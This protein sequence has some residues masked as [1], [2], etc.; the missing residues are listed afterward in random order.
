[1]ARINSKIRTWWG[2]SEI[3]FSTMAVMETSFF[4]VF[5][6]DAAQLP[7]PLVGAIT[8][9][10]GIA[11]AIS[12]VI[13]GAVIDRARLKGGKY[14]PWLVFC[15]PLVVLFFIFEFTRIGGD[16][17]A[18][19]ICA[20]G[21]IIGHFIWNIGW[22]ANRSLIGVLTD[23]PAERGFLSGRI[24]AGSCGGKL[25]GSYAVPALTTLFIGLFAALGPVF[26]YTITAAIVSVLY[27]LTYLIHYAITK[28]YD[29]PDTSGGEKAS[30]GATLLDIIKTIFT[31]PQLLVVVLADSFR[32]VGFYGFAAVAAYYARIVI[33]DASAVAIILIIFNGGAFV[34]SLLSGTVVRKLGT[35][36]VTIAG[37]G[38]M[39][40]LFLFLYFVPLPL[41]AFYV[42]LA[43]AEVVF[44]VSYGLTSSLYSMCGTLSE[45]QKGVDVK[46][47]AMAG[48]SLAIKVS[49]AVRGVII[50][51]FL[52]SIG[53]SADAA[54][55]ASMQAGI[56]Q[57][58][59]LVPAV[60]SLVS[61]LLF[62]L[63]RIKDD[64]I[65]KMEAEIAARKNA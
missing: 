17:M 60:F 11:D 41:V 20:A 49:I 15:P 24:A 39:A 31:N 21:Y 40:I 44:G 59:L 13:A 28:G 55:T 51:S 58:F 23:D 48:S 14:R 8:G 7:L 26:G 61:A 50:A 4:L 5:L 46:G 56:S 36:L 38:I 43:V 45:Y 30:R 22:T 63:Y 16:V 53:Y 47:M 64:D 54:I 1:M 34:G 52:A 42:V 62:F 65:P 37:T 3:G 19:I 12:A 2:I 32:L 9:V 18:S 35:K 6:T 57:L 10:T 33:G 29:V 27:L 25:I